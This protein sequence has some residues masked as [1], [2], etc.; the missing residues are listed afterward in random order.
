VLE[1]RLE[2]PRKSFTVSVD[3]Q[4]QT[5]SV[6]C[7]FGPSATG[8][9]SI[10]SVIA[11]FETAYKDA[12]LSIDGKVL[13]D[14]RTGP[15]NFYPPWRRGI[16]YLEQSARLFPHLTVAQNILYGA[17]R[18][19]V[20]AWFEDIVESLDLRDYLAVRPRQLSGGLTQRVALARALAARPRVLLLDEPFSALDWMARRV[21]QNF[22]L[23][24]HHKFPM[25]IVLVTHQLTEAQRM[26]NTIALIDQGQILQTGS[27][28]NLMESPSSW[29]VAQLLGYI[30]I[31]RGSDGGQYALHPDRMIIGRQPS[32]GISVDALIHDIVWKEGRQCALVKLQAPWETQETIEVNLAPTDNVQAGEYVPITFVHPPRVG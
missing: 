3:L 32:L 13:A 28:S 23:A 24:V 18:G 17:P 30:S 9:S 6:F 8:K 21:L 15:G 10:L 4:V 29:R 26:A 12:Y 25:T 22:V 19:P 7:L 5:N 16:G 20:D 11:G 2:L 31:L 1:L 14:T 27:P